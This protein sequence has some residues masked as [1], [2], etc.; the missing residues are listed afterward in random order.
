M[1]PNNKNHHSLCSFGRAAWALFFSRVKLNTSIISLLLVFYSFSVY[2]S[3]LELKT[4]LFKH[5]SKA[6]GMYICLYLGSKFDFAKDADE[7]F[8]KL[9]EKLKFPDELQKNIMDD[10]E[11]YWANNLLNFDED[12]TLVQSV[13]WKVNCEKPTQNIRAHFYGTMVEK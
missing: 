7:L 4:K 6:T 8:R 12:A 3:D 10:A 2:S 5:D 11:K 1:Q 9:S 13:Y